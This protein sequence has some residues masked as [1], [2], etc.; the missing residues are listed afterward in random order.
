MKNY[1]HRNLV[2]MIFQEML[3]KNTKARVA[4][5]VSPAWDIEKKY[6][7]NH[8]CLSMKNSPI[9]IFTLCLLLF[10]LI[11]QPVIALPASTAAS[12]NEDQIQA[13]R[14]SKAP[15]APSMPPL[16]TP[17]YSDIGAARPF[18]EVA[19][20]TDGNQDI[21]LFYN[22][23]TQTPHND[24]GSVVLPPGWTGY[25]LDFRIRDLY[26][27]RTWVLNPSFNG[28]ADNW[29]SGEY[30][31][32]G[33]D[34]GFTQAWHSGGPDGNG[35]VHVEETGVLTGGYYRY[36]ENDRTWWRQTYSANRSD[37]AWAAI[38]MDYRVDSAWD[39]NALFNVYIRINGTQ[40]WAK[41][42]QAVGDDGWHNSGFLEISPALFDIPNSAIELEVGIIST[43][44]VG[45]SSNNWMR[46]EF[47]NIWLYMKTKVY[48]SE[49]NLEMNDLAVLNEGARGSGNV[50]QIPA[51]VWTSS[52]VMAQLNWTPTTMPPNPDLEIRVTGVCDVNLYANK[53]GTSLYSQSPTATG[54]LFNVKSG[55]NA[56]WT[57][58]HLLAL[59]TQYWNDVFNFTIP[60]D[61]NITFVSEPQLPTINK[62]SQCQ[63]G[64]I[65]DGYLEIPASVITNSPDGYWAIKAESHNYVDSAELQ[66]WDGSWNPTVAVRSGN[67]TRVQARILDGSD[68]PPS[69]AA[70]TQA[71]VSVYNPDGMTIWYTELV[72]PTAAGWVTSNSFTIEGTTTIGGTYT[73]V[74]FWDNSTEAG[75][76]VTAYS[77]T[78]TTSLIPRDSWI[79]AFYEDQYWYPR[80]RFND[81]DKDEWLTPPAT[82]EG[83]WTTGTITFHYISGTGWFEAEINAL[84][85]G[86]V[87]RFFIRVNASKSYYDESYCVI[88]IDIVAETQLLIPQAPTVTVG[89]GNNETIEIRYWRKTDGAGVNGCILYSEVTFNWTMGYYTIWEVGNGWYNI[90]FNSSSQSPGQYTLNIS[91]SKERYQ[92]QQFF[93]TVIVRGRTSTLTPSYIPTVDFGGFI[94]IT[95]E[96]FDLD[97]HGRITNSSGYGAHVRIIVYNA[98]DPG[99]APINPGDYTVTELLDHRYR[100][101]IDTS[102]FGE[103]NV[104]H[105]FIINATWDAGYAPFYGNGTTSITVYVVGTKTTVIYTPP[106]PQPYGDD[107]IFLIKFNETDFPYDPVDNVTW[108]AHVRITALCTSHIFSLNYEVQM[109]N[110]GINGYRLIFHT[111]NFPA[112]GQYT[113]EVN[114]T[115]PTNI[116]PYYQSHTVLLSGY[117]R[118]VR[119]SLTYQLPGSLYWGDAL[120]LLVTFR[121]DDNSVVLYDPTN[122]TVT[123]WLNWTDWSIVQIFGNGTYQIRVNTTLEEVGLASLTIRFARNFYETRQQLI[124]FTINPLPLYVQILS[125]SPWTAEYADTVVITVRVTDEYGRLIND[126]TTIYHWAGLPDV[127]L[128]F[129]GA[130]VYNISFLAT[131]DVGTYLVTIE[132]QKL[133]CQT[134]IGIITLYILPVDTSLIIL[135]PTITVVVGS[136][137]SISANFSTVSGIPI[138]TATL[139]YSWAGGNGSLTHVGS[140][141]YNATLDSTGL[142][143]GQ[144]NIYVTASSPNVVERLG[145]ITALLDLIPTLLEVPFTVIN[146]NWSDY[147]TISV[148]FKDTF[149]NLPIENAN[150]TYIWGETTG[151]LQE[152]GVPGWYNI[153]LPTNI[154]SVGIFDILLSVDH[155]GYH[156][157]L[158]TISVNIFNQPTKVEIIDV[159][160]YYESANITVP[161]LE[162]PWTLPLGDYLQVILNF[163]DS[164]DN[165][166]VNAAATYSI[167]GAQGTLVYQNGY[168]VLNL[169]MTHIPVGMYALNIYL[170]RQNYQTGQLVD[171]SVNLIRIPTAIVAVSL[172]PVVETGTVF[173]VIVFLNDTYHNLPV[174]GVT[175]T[176]TISGILDNALMFDNG[177][178]SYIYTGL[179]FPSERTYDLLIAAEEFGYYASS[180]QTFSIYARLSQVVQTIIQFGAIA[181]L[182]GIIILAIWLAYSKVFSIPWL[183]RKMRSMSRTIGRGKTPT[184][185][186]RDINRIATRPDQM[187]DIIE[188]A[189]DAIGIS[190]PLTVIPAAIAV[191]EREAEDE[192]V[193]QELEKLEG[194]GHDQKLEL[195]EEMKRIPPKD[196]VWFIEDLKQQMADGT[197]F[198]RVARRPTPVPEGVDPEV[199]A[200]LVSITTLGDE[201][202]EAVIEQLRGLSKEEQEEVIRALEET[203]AGD[204]ED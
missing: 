164:H 63:G 141:I 99:L 146:V 122:T 60:A 177:D 187:A 144:Y 148:Y 97:G 71:N 125:T 81:T 162:T 78:H 77:V 15:A 181:A 19:N 156:R 38:K 110:N 128:T 184:L 57:F 52:P 189:Y 46:G 138:T 62:I 55:Q 126:S 190:L 58:Y 61:W 72:I 33:Y 170:Q 124:Q 73:I 37:I 202:K 95:L 150:I 65:G 26:E 12:N 29:T 186:K 131:Q 158:R 102:S 183:V 199:H 67:L 36:D 180:T 147:V 3:L 105:H 194:L 18:H 32:V 129:L 6:H 182:L 176:I 25:Q 41:G 166:V 115:W 203:E 200:R 111:D 160:A 89:W 142:D 84:D 130:G 103:V 136:S 175:V 53:T 120:Y 82:V 76:Y 201:E 98:S 152:T 174:T 192:T 94:N 42:F 172:P 23:S 75:E 27:N 11:M 96:Y 118:A 157:S 85:P 13:P 167:A 20:R 133:N 123:T 40:V 113:F 198:G 4:I 193:W 74:V 159:A 56:S 8:R 185:S 30:D 117:V 92:H 1:Q 107:M 134:G 59:P 163:T 154:V 64:N 68:T 28:N 2:S 135:T 161:I 153:T 54:V 39:S 165:P 86:D 51:S 91:L 145:L 47:D 24:S 17:D 121:D 108:G 204:K 49:V 21:L 16:P 48:P 43:M 104:F 50:S 132:A 149:N 93:L 196:R 140:G 191:D 155:L 178:G 143:L 127:P 9:V 69:G 7:T 101:L 109:I 173:D 5:R 22:S 31:V 100:V 80:V 151:S 195:F 34:N 114:V 139:L 188:P 87:G 79:D 169:N 112:L 44:T 35:Y 197:R 45:Y 116:A 119:T 70:S 106:E 83:N 168:Y 14:N 88:V 10:P 171:R 66:I 179:S 137:F 90:E